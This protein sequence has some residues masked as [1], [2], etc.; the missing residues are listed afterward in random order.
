[1]HLV[2]VVVGHEEG[3]H[4]AVY[5]D[6]HMRVETRRQRPQHLRL[7]LTVC[8]QDVRLTRLLMLVVF[9]KLYAVVA[10]ILTYR[11]GYDCRK[12]VS[13]DPGSNQVERQFSRDSAPLKKFQTLKTTEGV[14]C[15][16]SSCRR[17]PEAAVTAFVLGCV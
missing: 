7:R 13:I 11:P 8:K 9:M 1:M 15:R 14:G 3:L 6:P 4:S 2:A 16:G 17:F 5:V 10:V 12:V